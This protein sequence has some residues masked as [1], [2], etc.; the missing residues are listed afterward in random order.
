MTRRKATRQQIRAKQRAGRRSTPRVGRPV[1]LAVGGALVVAA[2]I[3]VVATGGNNEDQQAPS[4]AGVTVT[5]EAL[6]AFAEGDDPAVGSPA[7]SLQGEDFAGN[8]VRIGEDGRPKAVVF[9]A[10]WCPH[11]QREVPLIQDWLDAQGPPEGVD[12]YSVATSIDPSQPNYPPDAWLERE[13]W[14]VP[15]LVDDSMDSAATAYGLTLFPYFVFIDAEGNVVARA[16]GE[17]TIE[18][19]EDY[20]VQTSP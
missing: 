10:H 9:L 20:L 1:I 3:A 13:G 2:V 5:G 14:S 19:L 7:P 12:L 18:Q 17:L 16:S 8:P 6:P 4:A 15:V 11:C